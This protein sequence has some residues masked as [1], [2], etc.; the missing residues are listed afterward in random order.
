MRICVQQDGS[1]INILMHYRIAPLLLTITVCL[2]YCS[3]RTEGTSYVPEPDDYPS[4][5]DTLTAVKVECNLHALRPRNLLISNDHLVVVDQSDNNVF[6]V[7]PLP[8]TGEGFSAVHYGK[9]PEEII[10]PDYISIKDYGDGIIV[11]DKDDYLKTFCI[12]GQSVRLVNKERLYRDGFQPGLFKLGNKILEYNDNREVN[13]SEYHVLTS[14]G[15]QEYIGAVPEWDDGITTKKSGL[16]YTNLRA[17]HPNGKLFAEFFWRFRKVR[18]LDDNGNVLSET[19]INYPSSSDRIPD[20]EGVYITYGSIPCASKTRILQ[21]AQNEF[22][23]KKSEN[24]IPRTLSE[25]QIWDWEG[26]LLKRFIIKEHLELFTV[27]F[28]SGI[29]YGIDPN[30]ENIVFTANI[31][32]L[33][34]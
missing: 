4:I 31:R 6:N 27:D 28:K 24:I 16:Y 13:N 20:S 34:E 23:F 25:F 10:D 14:D 11:A 2:A 21:L 29:F 19:A 9:G 22:V 30:R 7:F 33:L 17:I 12:N 18:I 5:T 3:R 1:V 32:N 8:F 26:H 15:K